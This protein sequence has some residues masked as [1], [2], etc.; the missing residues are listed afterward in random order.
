VDGQKGASKDPVD[1]LG[2]LVVMAPK[3]IGADFSKNWQKV[4]APGTY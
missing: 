4:N 1:A 2:Y 3:H